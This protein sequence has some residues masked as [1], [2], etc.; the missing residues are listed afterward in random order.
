MTMT[1]NLKEA[2]LEYAGLGW[3]VIPLHN[4]DAAGK[5]SCGAGRCSSPGKHPRLADWPAKSSCD[6]DIVNRWWA[7]WPNANIGVHMGKSGLLGV[8]LDT[9]R[10]TDGPANW[11]ALNIECRTHMASTAN[12]GFHLYLLV[13][14]EYTKSASKVAPGI[15]IQCGD[16]YLVAPPSRIGEKG[17]TWIDDDPVLPMPQALVELLKPKVRDV[18]RQ[19]VASNGNRYGKKALEDECRT[20]A[21][22]AEGTRNNQLNNAALSLGKLVAGGV[23]SE[24]EVFAALLNACAA[25]GLLA[26]DGEAQCRKT[27]ASGFKAGLKQPRG[28]PEKF[29]RV[30]SE[31]PPAWMDED[32]GPSPDLD[33]NEK[34]TEQ[35]NMT[36]LGNSER[37]AAMHGGDLLWCDPWS[38]WLCWDGK[39]WRKDDTREIDRRVNDV[40]RSIY[41][42][43]AAEPDSDRRKA[44]GT[45]AHQCEGA[46]RRRAIA[47]GARSMLPARPSEFD[48]DPWLLNVDSGTLDLRTGE[49]KTHERC[50]MLTKLAPV[51]YDPDAKAPTWEAFLQRI[52]AG[53]EDL[54]GFLQRAVG[55]SLTGD[56]R[57]QV[58]FICYGTGANGKSTFL[59]ALSAALGDYAQKTP[60]ETLLTK[61]GGGIPN[62]V[63]RLRGA[64]MVTA[65]EAEEGRHM[66]ESL[67]KQMTGG[68]TVAARFLHQ[69]FFE[70]V[71]AF[72]LWLA[73]NHKPVIR[74]TDYAIWRRIRLIPFTVTIPEEDQDHGLGEKLKAELPGILAWAVRGCTEWQ[75]NGLGTPSE[76]SQATDA[77]RAEMD[78][79]GSWL[80]SCCTLGPTASGRAGE[81][82]N[83]YKEW[84]AVSGERA[85]GSKTF[86]QALEER[87]FD[88]ARDTKGVFYIGIGLLAM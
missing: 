36:D 66:A 14:G 84:C 18:Q 79:L 78:V 29:T 8:D 53:N 22:T 56:T 75:K 2:A 40:V 58:F 65:V 33:S 57:E 11:D 74:G 72:K 54:I 7:R 24:D 9:K 64:R 46:F 77:Y 85:T 88:K 51:E 45:W 13:D 37:M 73:T 21:G 43:A 55:Y 10:G 48:T 60:T 67:V 81:L 6:Q 87:G 41:A 39:R 61:R 35:F 50:D 52:M 68:D 20:L 49:R 62:D 16:A 19:V 83:S 26:E 17:Y 1:D 12:G 27:I 25:N 44:L 86:W 32:P 5:C 31:E 23:L 59:E 71:P 80:D 28:V 15:D 70:F 34:R 30:N 47:E 69:E 38:S 76:V 63:A 42:E 3:Y 82:Y 4:T